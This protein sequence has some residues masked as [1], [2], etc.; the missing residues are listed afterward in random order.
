MEIPTRS[1]SRKVWT[2]RSKT[3]CD[4]RRLELAA[5]EVNECQN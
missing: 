2:R 5:L 3:F 1:Q 4:R